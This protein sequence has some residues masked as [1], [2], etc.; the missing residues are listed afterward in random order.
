MYEPERRR[1]QS[2]DGPG[3]LYSSH[4][5]LRT[6]WRLMVFAAL[7]FAASQ[8]VPTIVIPLFSL[9][10]RWAGEP[11]P[12]YSWVMLAAV[13]VAIVLMLRI[14]EQETWES[15]G[16]GGAHWRS[17]PLFIGWLLGAILIAA[18]GVLLA[19]GGYLRFD[20]VSMPVI[21]GVTVPF[22][23]AWVATAFRL[24]VLL[25]PAAL[26]EELVFRGYLWKVAED[27][28]GEM[29]ALWSS[30]VAFGLV[31][32]YNPN[33]G[34]RTTILVVLAGLC[35]GLVRLRIGLPA[36]WL[37]HLAWNWVMAAVLHVPVSGIGFETPGYRADVGGPSWLTGGDWGPEGGMVAAVVMTGALM[38]AER[39]RA[40]RWSAN[41]SGIERRRSNASS[42]TERS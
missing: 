35:L 8:I 22:Y 33:A 38:I 1:R 20:V 24:L 41:L 4:G 30:S 14:I 39:K 11:I 27:A 7:L 42:Q 17:R 10:S 13:F 9:I 26:W 31:H 37:A 3:W 36:A 5:R 23:Q 12:A 19:L 16:L 40:G 6:P 29:V 34:I 32:L 21:D 2:A 18:T 25:A 28:G 15:I